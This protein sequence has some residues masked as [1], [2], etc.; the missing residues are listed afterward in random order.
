MHFDGLFLFFLPHPHAEKERYREMSGVRRLL[1]GEEE[2]EQEGEMSS[3]LVIDLTGEKTKKEE[4]EELIERLVC[5]FEC[6]AVYDEYVY[7][8]RYEGESWPWDDEPFTFRVAPSSDKE[9]DEKDVVKDVHARLFVASNTES[10]PEG[11]RSKE[12]RRLSSIQDDDE[13]YREFM[14]KFELDCRVWYRIYRYVYKPTGNADE[15]ARVMKAWTQQEAACKKIVKRILLE[16]DSEEDDMLN[17]RFKTLLG[18][19]FPEFYRAKLDFDVRQA[20]K[21][22]Y[23]SDS[24]GC[25]D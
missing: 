21:K 7:V 17:A 9:P 1:G 25:Y 12:W 11:M 6:Q 15:H 14:E 20:T 18:N 13:F 23:M 5:R 16:I 10:R 3:L 2:E 24:E 22:V 19:D 4:F 8:I